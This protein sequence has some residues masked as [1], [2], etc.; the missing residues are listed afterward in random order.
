[1]LC[2]RIHLHDHLRR[3]DDHQERQGIALRARA[4]EHAGADAR[5]IRRW[6]GAGWALVSAKDGDGNPVAVAGDPT[7][8]IADDGTLNG[9]DGCNSLNGNRDGRRRPAHV[10]AGRWHGEVLPRRRR[11]DREGDPRVHARHRPRDRSGWRTDDD[12][13]PGRTRLPLGPDRGRH[14]RRATT[15]RDVAARRRRRYA[16]PVRH[17]GGLLRSRLDRPERNAAPTQCGN[18]RCRRPAVRV[19]VASVVRARATGSTSC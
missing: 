4:A 9:S 15:A 17:H 11:R 19:L 14:R 2:R 12:E 6:S 18:V 3:A 5:L 16:A 8:H 13:G 7:L 1:M 10:R